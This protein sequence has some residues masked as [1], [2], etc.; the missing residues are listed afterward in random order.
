MLK[1]SR[2][3]WGEENAQWCVQ[4]QHVEEEVERK[5]ST[6]T[7]NNVGASVPL[8][9]KDRSKPSKNGPVTSANNG[10]LE[11]GNSITWC[12]SVGRNDPPQPCNLRV[13]VVEVQMRRESTPVLYSAGQSLHE[14]NEKPERRSSRRNGCLSKSKWI[15]KESL[16]KMRRVQREDYGLRKKRWMKHK[17]DKNVQERGISDYYGRKNAGRRTAH[18]RVCVWTLS[19]EG[20]DVTGEES[21][22]AFCDAQDEERV[23]DCVFI[24]GD[25]QQSGSD[26]KCPVM[27]VTRS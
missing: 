23:E 10:R 20:D 3:W 12:A 17:T 13:T 24:E 25:L 19:K 22:V 27:G 21:L 8:T 26:L 5:M 2:S 16:Q 7:P 11:A 9:A 4:R 15:F 14:W 18:D 6:D 1:G